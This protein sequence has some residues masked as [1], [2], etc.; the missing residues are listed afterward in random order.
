MRRQWIIAIMGVCIAAWVG[1][2]DYVYVATNGS[3]QTP[4]S[5]WAKAATN[6][7]VGVS[8][9]A[10]GDTV[11]VGPGTYQIGGAYTTDGLTNVLAITKDITV[12]GVN[13]PM[14]T[15]IK[16][17]TTAT[18]GAKARRCVF[19]NSG[20]SLIGFMLRGGATRT[21][22]D[23][24]LG[25]SGGGLY[26]DSNAYVSNCLIRYC[27]ANKYGGGVYGTG[28]VL[29]KCE[30]Y[31]NESW[32]G[33][34]VAGDVELRECTLVANTA[35]G[36]GSLGGGAYGCGVIGD[37]AMIGNEAGSWGGGAYGCGVY[38]GDVN[39]NTAGERG[40]GL[41]AGTATV[42]RISNNEA[43]LGGGVYACVLNSSTCAYNRAT[44]DGGG[45]ANSDVVSSELSNNSATNRGGGA[46]QCYVYTSDVIRNNAENGAGSAYSTNISSWIAEN[47][48]YTSG[49]GVLDGY[50]W[51][52]DIVSNAAVFRGAGMTDAARGVRC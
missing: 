12:I 10:K 39:G 7:Q 40:G 15:V 25:E 24:Y 38:G 2:A 36:G 14:A 46:F 4:F 32:R 11:R 21:S 23:D 18:P 30:L 6:I 50:T 48:A 28:G 45:A 19:I 8:V 16:A 47:S 34:G 41:Y 3:H 33:G 20:A 52:C 51:N 22:G 27:E 31:D 37:S 29:E 9:A 26:I 49:G 5:S 13:G 42:A 44:M 35:S 17:S 43:P 1:H